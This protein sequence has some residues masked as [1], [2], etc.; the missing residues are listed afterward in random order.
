MVKK[1]ARI[2]RFVLYG[3]VILGVLGI[4]A[5]ALVVRPLQIHQQKQNFAKAEASLDALEKQIEDKAGKPDQILKSKT[6]SRAHLLSESG[7]LGCDVT[8][9]LNFTSKDAG[10]ATNIM[11]QVKALSSE[12]I[13]IGSGVTTGTSFKSAQLVR[14]TQIY[15]QSIPSIS[16]LTCAVGYNYPARNTPNTL[17]DSS[18]SFSLD[19]SCGGPA[20]A[21]FYPVKN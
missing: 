15:Y 13:R 4:V 19:V 16:S 2:I 17:R 9:S 10:S 3:L 1:Y 18:S 8:I 7:P 6:C 14:G 5:Y 21:E 20:M 12:P 11:N